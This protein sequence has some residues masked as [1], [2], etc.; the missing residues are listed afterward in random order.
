MFNRELWHVCIYRHMYYL[1]HAP[2]FYA[3]V[4]NLIRRTVSWG[5]F[6]T[7]T[8]RLLKLWF[9]IEFSDYGTNIGSLLSLRSLYSRYILNLSLRLSLSS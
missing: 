1:I 6:M 4:S 8:C 5:G 2:Y 7:G 3:Q 9:S